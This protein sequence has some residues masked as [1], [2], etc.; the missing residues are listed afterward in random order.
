[1]EDISHGGVIE[2]RKVWEKVMLQSA[3]HQWTIQW[4]HL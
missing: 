4:L 2:T 3:R 1:M